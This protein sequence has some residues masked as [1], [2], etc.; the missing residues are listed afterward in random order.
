[1]PFR[2]L[3]TMFSVSLIASTAT[4]GQCYAPS[5]PVRLTDLEQRAV[6]LNVNDNA[7]VFASDFSLK[8][9]L[10]NILSTT[11]GADPAA[12]G[13][14]QIEALLSTMLDDLASSEIENEDAGITYKVQ[15]RPGEAR[16]TAKALLTP[17]GPDEMK[18]V[19]LFNRLDLTP[20]DFSNCGE[21]R[22]VYAKNS[23]K[24][25]VDTDPSPQFD[26]RLTLIFEAAL[27]NPDQ[28]GDPKQCQAV[29]NM[30]KSFGASSASGKLSDAEIGAQLAKFYFDGG[31]IGSSLSFEPVVDYRHYGLASG[32]VRANA[33][34]QPSDTHPGAGPALNWHLRQWRV[35]FDANSP[36]STAIFQ[37]RALNENPVPGL[38]DSMNPGV[39]PGDEDRFKNLSGLFQNTFLRTNVPQ[40]TAVDSLAAIPSPTQTTIADLIDNVGVDIDD[41]FYAVDSDAGS[42]RGPAADDPAE[43]VKDGSDLSN[44]VFDRLARLKV[45]DAC[46]I[47]PKH[48]LNRMGAMTCA[49]C[50]QFSN[51]KEIAPGIRW[52]LSSTFVHIAESGE[53]SNLLLDRFLPF[54]FHLMDGLPPTT[55]SLPQVLSLNGVELSLKDLAQRRL[56]L[57]VQLSTLSNDKTPAKLDK[58][59]DLS[60]QIRQLD[61]SQIGAFVTFRKPD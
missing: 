19:G 10:K 56:D 37:P 46:G 35:F 18:P 16:L 40:L 20:G 38:F 50:H 48:V 57:N 2:H 61:K 60:D 21:F 55:P 49:G 47:T 33:F 23:H 17:N 27:T 31:K 39:K 15:P 26:D 9:T 30:W 54:R 36:N 28:A 1:M 22:I 7:P 5:D 59:S 52:P 44:Q 3:V 13:D 12:I 24:G 42:P 51:G 29:W 4:A 43:R 11:P 32:Q 14:V 34:V 41:R 53:M 58:V 6:V 8:R 45:G 25:G